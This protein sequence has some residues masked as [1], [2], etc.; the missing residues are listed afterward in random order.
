MK[1]NILINKI[2][3]RL[4]RT[5]FFWF[6]KKYYTYFVSIVLPYYYNSRKYNNTFLLNTSTSEDKSTKLPVPQ[7]IFVFWTGDNEMSEN[8]KRC[9]ES[10]KSISGVKVQLITTDNLGEFILEDYPLHPAYKYLSYVHRADYL[11]CYFMNYYGGGY[12]DIKSIRKSWLEVFYKINKTDA[13][14]IGYPEK[15][16]DGVAWYEQKDE[17]LK[18]DLYKYWRLMIGNC[19]YICRP[20]T[21]FTEE[22]LAEIHRRL[23]KYLPTLEKFPSDKDPYNNTGTN[24]PIC[25]TEICGS[26]FHPLCLKYNKRIL[27]DNR[28]FPIISNYR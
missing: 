9:L 27:R 8:R 5:K 19:A 25:W 16:F 4:N 28:L 22:W 12:V 2:Y 24:Y 15:N 10:I 23:D 14:I 13:Y 18:S 26:I 3:S 7:I 20:R 1:K 11:R 6:C 21:K 17:N